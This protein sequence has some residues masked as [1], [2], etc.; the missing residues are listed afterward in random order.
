MVQ[1][2]ILSGKKAGVTWVARR[3][4]VR[5][6]RAPGADLRVEEDG[7]WDQHLLLQLKPRTGFLLTKQHNALA[8]V[9][10]QPIEQTVLRNGDLIQIGSLKLEFLLADTRQSGLGLREV[11]TWTGI[12]G[13]S[14]AQLVLLYWLIK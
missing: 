1:F 5:I 7:V 8:S 14:L 12:L 10:G 6:G 11:V 3:F 9:N 13:I 2:R 4:P